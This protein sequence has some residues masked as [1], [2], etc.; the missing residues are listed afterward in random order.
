MEGCHKSKIKGIITVHNPHIIE[1]ISSQKCHSSKDGFVLPRMQ[2][3]LKDESHMPRS[4]S[5]CFVNGWLSEKSVKN[6]Q[7]KVDYECSD[8]REMYN[9][10]MESE[11]QLQSDLGT[12][13]DNDIEMKKRK[14]RLLSKKW[15]EHT[16][17][18]L[19]KKILNEV[20]GKSYEMLDKEKR[21]QYT[22]Y[23][24]HQN[25]REGHVFL[26][27]FAEE[28]YNPLHVNSQRPGPLKAVTGKLVD[29]LLH[30]QDKH[31]EE[32][33][34]VLAC[35]LGEIFSDKEIESQRL[36]KLPLIPL[37]RHGTVCSSWLGMELTDIQS[38]VRVRS[39]VRRNVNRNKS[40]YGFEENGKTADE[41]R[42]IPHIKMWHKRKQFPEKY[43]T[44][45]ELL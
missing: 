33:R 37:G 12:I 21:K 27:V 13:I 7:E 16:Y 39:Q 43:D 23:L 28:E 1:T 9:S 4:Y 14:M 26:D 41:D 10:L 22:N 8:I 45:V 30:L 2:G 24:N 17:L 36:P 35:D 31:N 11:K 18:P 15:H 6:I 32:D 38:D 19:T 44:T 34:I 42:K 20:N 25:N 40:A 3:V 5:S 29:P